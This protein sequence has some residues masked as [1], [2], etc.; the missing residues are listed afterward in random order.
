MT[1][2]PKF[3]G[4]EVCIKGSH[5]EA[6]GEA[7]RTYKIRIYPTEIVHAGKTPG[8]K[9]GRRWKAILRVSLFHSFWSIAPRV[10]RLLRGVGRLA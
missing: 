5:V 2:N 6:A 10:V 9:K 7:E 4:V 1:L 8:L 3:K